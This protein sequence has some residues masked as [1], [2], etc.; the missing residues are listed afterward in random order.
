MRAAPRVHP[1]HLGAPHRSG[2]GWTFGLDLR[3]YRAAA[4]AA[5]ASTDP[6][7][8]SVAGL[9]FAGPP[10]TLLPY[11]PAALPSEGVAIIVYGSLTLLCAVVALRTVRLHVWWLLFPPISDSLIVLNSDVAVIALL[12]ALPRLEAVS[13][14][15][16]VYAALPLAI[17]RRW[18]PLAVGLGLCLLSAALPAVATIAYA[19]Q[20][21]LLGLAAPYRA[22]AA[23]T[24]PSSSS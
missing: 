19:A 16:K 22:G 3:I 6:W 8:A 21:W 23:K 18:R 2:R 12:V 10:P 13:I 11:L 7:T 17:G 14:V 20:V 9:T 5:I 15:L 4:A 1:E 24:A